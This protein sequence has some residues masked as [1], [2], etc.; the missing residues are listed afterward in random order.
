[1]T[2]QQVNL[3]LGGF[4]VKTQILV[5]SIFLIAGFNSTHAS[6]IGKSFHFKLTQTSSTELSIDV[7]AR[8]NSNSGVSSLV[9][10]QGRQLCSGGAHSARTCS[11]QFHK[12]SQGIPGF[13]GQVFL[14]KNSKFGA[15]KSILLDA[16]IDASRIL[17][18]EPTRLVLSVPNLTTALGLPAFRSQG[19]STLIQYRCTS[20]SDCTLE[21][22]NHFGI[23]WQDWN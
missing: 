7:R 13:S 14:S 20:T 12:V 8:N 5:F 23:N 9:G 21:F 19:T 6:T 3:V 22:V 10:V 18:M 2:N 11:Y 16:D 4:T 1:M 15:R 17:I